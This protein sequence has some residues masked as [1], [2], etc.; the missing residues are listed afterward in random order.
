MFATRR[1][2]R[3]GRGALSP[4]SSTI[5]GRDRA[6]APLLSPAF[7]VPRRVEVRKLVAMPQRLLQDP[8]AFPGYP[9]PD[10]FRNLEAIR[11]RIVGRTLR[12]QRDIVQILRPAF[13]FMLHFGL[14]TTQ[15]VGSA[16]G[17]PDILVP[18]M[19]REVVAHRSAVHAGRRCFPETS[20]L[21]VAGASAH[22][23]AA[24]AACPRPQ[25]PSR[26][27]S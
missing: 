20:I 27:H 17:A 18:G 9:V 26:R 22:S 6:G 16:P 14:Q 7:H 1:K 11:P 10:R 3:A 8:Y 21:K 15:D 12:R 23:R 5:A 2:D 25:S 13:P 4:Y 24:I 19:R